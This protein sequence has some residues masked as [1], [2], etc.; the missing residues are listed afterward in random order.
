LA[1]AALK[2]YF[3][4]TDSFAD[5]K[6]V[7]PVPVLSLAATLEL[8][9]AIAAIQAL[10]RNRFNAAWLLLTTT[11]FLMFVVA[12][13]RWILGH[14]N[15]GCFG[16]IEFPSWIAALTDG[17]I[18]SVLLAIR[19]PAEA[20]IA[21]G[22]TE[23]KSFFSST[24]PGWIGVVLAMV[25]FVGIGNLS[26]HGAL[27]RFKG[28]EAIASERIYLPPLHQNQSTTIALPLRNASRT[29]A[30]VVGVSRSCQCVVVHSDWR[31][32]QAG[33]AAAFSVQVHPK[34]VG[35]FHQRLVF[36]LDHPD[37]DRVSFDL[38]GQVN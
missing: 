32:I 24:N 2:F 4:A 31:R 13:G 17:A 15:C 6:T 28:S 3:L 33:E 25:A 27:G 29:D 11:W 34:S 12:A 37:Q 10:L 14:Q 16:A 35:R 8:A 19:H 38:V 5:L 20:R 26:K 18:F 1:S 23:I 22:V 21:N 7:F 9:I 30:T 36:F